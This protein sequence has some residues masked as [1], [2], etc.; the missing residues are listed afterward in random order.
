MTLADLQRDVN[1]EL[2]K[3]SPGPVTLHVTEH[4]TPV[5]RPFRLEELFFPRPVDR[6]V[7]AG[8]LFARQRNGPAVVWLE[9]VDL[10]QADPASLARRIRNALLGGP[11]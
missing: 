9:G 2:Q 10:D 4:D 5:R 1:V 11:L 3:F 6:V 7:P 8:T